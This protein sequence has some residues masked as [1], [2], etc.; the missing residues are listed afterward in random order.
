MGGRGGSGQ[1]RGSFPR[2][3]NG[4]NNNGGGNGNI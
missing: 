2:Q 4:N 3:N 1:R